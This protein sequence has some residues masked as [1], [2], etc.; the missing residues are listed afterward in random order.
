MLASDSTERNDFCFFYF[1][2]FKL[3]ISSEFGSPPLEQLCLIFAGKIMKDH[4][5]LLSHNVKDGM[6]VHL[7]IKTGGS[8][9]GSPNNNQTA[10]EPRPAPQP[11]NE[12]SSVNYNWRGVL[13][14]FVLRHYLS[15]DCTQKHM[16]C[17]IMVM[18]T[19]LRSNDFPK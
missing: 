7:V 8:G 11:G 12:D 6:T 17:I 13:S 5:T 10:S 9:A 19:H 18:K 14:E 1:Q 15:V 2:Q 16:Q 3:K 4:E